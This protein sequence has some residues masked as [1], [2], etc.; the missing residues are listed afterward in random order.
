MVFDNVAMFDAVGTIAGAVVS[1]W[2]VLKI[3]VTIRDLMRKRRDEPFS[4][5]EGKLDTI[6]NDVDQIKKDMQ[7]QADAIATL[8]LNELNSA[9]VH[10]VDHGRPCPMSVKSSLGEMFKQYK[11]KAGR[12][13]V[14]E[15]YIER[16]IELPVDTHT[17]A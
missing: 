11:S 16:L 2:A 4:E 14:A 6:I 13:H 7:E 5:I 8:Q 3:I 10:Y 17:M 9:F 1:V 12:N 15:D